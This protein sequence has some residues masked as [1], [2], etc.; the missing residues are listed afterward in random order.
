MCTVQTG[1]PLCLILAGGEGKEN[2]E[3]ACPLWPMWHMTLP[4]ILSRENLVTWPY[5]TSW[6]PGEGIVSG[7]G[8]HAMCPTTIL[9]LWSKERMDFG[10]QLTVSPLNKHKVPLFSVFLFN[11]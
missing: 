8:R 7:I 10:G 3:K 2:V 9:L 1:S 11:N 5:L 6:G 4:P